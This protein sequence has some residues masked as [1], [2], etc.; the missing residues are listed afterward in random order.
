LW[1]PLAMLT[2]VIVLG[3]AFCVLA[4]WLAMRQPLLGSL[5]SDR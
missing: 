1:G 4:A 2:W 3:L 5:R